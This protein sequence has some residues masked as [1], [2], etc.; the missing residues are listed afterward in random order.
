M[1]TKIVWQ[2]D[3]SQPDNA[4]NFTA[5]KQWWAALNAKEVAWQ[6]RLIPES[7]NPDEIDWDSQRFDEKFALQLPEIR[8]ITL[9]WYKPGSEGTRNI[10]AKK[11]ELDTARQKLYIY[12]LSQ[13]QLVIRVGKPDI[14]YQTIELKDPLIAG[15]SVGDNCVLLLRDSRQQIEVKLTLSR[16]S[17][18]K[19]LENLPG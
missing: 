2:Q 16:A 12:P 6:Q 8:G 4:N 18:G 15:T 17:L 10:T 7:G 3:S 11:L 5:I 14:I 13:P 1:P 19:L 9:Y